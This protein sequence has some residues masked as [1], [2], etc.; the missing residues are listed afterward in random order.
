[1][2]GDFENPRY[3]TRVMC[4]VMGMSEEDR[5]RLQEMAWRRHSGE[6]VVRPAVKPALKEA[7]KVDADA[8]EIRLALEFY[9]KHLQANRERQARYRERRRK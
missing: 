9:R 6:A 2:C 7:L 1:M 3:V 5:K 4:Y 8:E